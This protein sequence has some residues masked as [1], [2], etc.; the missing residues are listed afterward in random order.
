MRF[1]AEY[2]WTFDGES[3]VCLLKREVQTIM[4]AVVIVHCIPKKNKYCLTI[5]RHC[6]T[7]SKD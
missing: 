5:H 3:P 2:L 7:I 4:E 6:I 1:S